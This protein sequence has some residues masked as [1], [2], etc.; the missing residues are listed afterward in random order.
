M[1]ALLVATTVTSMFVA[2]LLAMAHAQPA[3]EGP[4]PEWAAESVAAPVSAEP[5]PEMSL[6]DQLDEAKRA[7]LEFRAQGYDWGNLGLLFALIAAITHLL[8]TAVKRV[9]KLT[10]RG[11][12]FLPWVAL[13]LGLVAAFA[14][15]YTG[16]IVTALVY[17]AGPVAAVIAQELGY[18]KLG[19]ALLDGL[20]AF[21][22]SRSK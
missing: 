7:L 3:D 22:G 17:G 21:V 20:K 1:K 15:S 12:K 4:A 13:G 18:G 19:Q 9:A 8:L 10:S 14:G 16:S 11:K 5:A 6:L 2:G